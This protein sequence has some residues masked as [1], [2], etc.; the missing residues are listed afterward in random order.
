MHSGIIPK[1]SDRLQ[2]ALISKR[3]HGNNN[4]GYFDD[5]TFTVTD[6]EPGFPVKLL[7]TTW[8]SNNG[9]DFI[10]F[11]NEKHGLRRVSHTAE[12]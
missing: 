3:V 6:E 1:G 5:I 2:I 12:V 4:N 10:T 7:G 11:I 8:T 9:K